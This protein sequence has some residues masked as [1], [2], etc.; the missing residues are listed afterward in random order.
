[1][2]NRHLAR[3][4]VMQSL[5]QWD[6]K[7]KPSAAIP[8]IVRQNTKEFGG[9]VENEKTYIEKTVD[10]VIEHLEMIDKIIKSYAPNWPL[11]QIALVDRNILRIGI[12]ELQINK[13][14]PAKVAINEAIE[15]AKTYGGPSSGK[16]VNG[17]LGAIYKDMSE[18]KK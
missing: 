3:S 10:G 4:I 12:Y 2:S 11:E 6:F 5:Y 9:G 8:E 1:M 18:K 17:I 7:G 14:I 15:V 13:D 16:F